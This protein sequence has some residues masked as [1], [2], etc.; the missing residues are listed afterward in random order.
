MDCH[1]F[2]I[3]EPIGDGAYRVHK[4]DCRRLYWDQELHTCVREIP[5]GAANC[6]DNE[7]LPD[8]LF[9]TPTPVEPG[10]AI[11]YIT[12]VDVSPLLVY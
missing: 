2:Y 12:V 11:L 7:P 5:V 8:F 9:T 3:C 1:K 6:I 4:G 10:K